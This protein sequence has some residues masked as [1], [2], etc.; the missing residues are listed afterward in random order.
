MFPIIKLHILEHTSDEQL[1]I[2][3]DYED[4]KEV[5]L[6]KKKQ[7]YKAESTI[8]DMCGKSFSKKS[9]EQ[10]KLLHSEVRPHPCIEC[11]KSFVTITN[12]KVN[13]F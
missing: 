12:L 5:L 11:G 13:N 7:E 2:V 3:K 4:L 9:I 10:H 8:C 6:N 1:Q